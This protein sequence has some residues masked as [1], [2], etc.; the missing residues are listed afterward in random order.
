M[1]LILMKISSQCKK[2]Q[3]NLSLKKYTTFS[4][5]KIFVFVRK[6]VTCLF[7]KFTQNHFAG[8]AT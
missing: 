3:K 5:C 2:K 6:N 1:C 4:L 8:E 7:V